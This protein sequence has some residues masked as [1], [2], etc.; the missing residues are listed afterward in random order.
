MDMDKEQDLLKRIQAGMP[1][2][3]KGQKL[4]A[5]FIINHYDKAAYMTAA[6]LGEEVGVSESTV[7]RFANEIGFDGYPKLQ[8]VL[9]EMNKSKLTAVQRI[10]VTSS[11]INEGNILK[12]VLQS[13]MEKIKATLE[14]IDQESFNN[15][16]K[17]IL[18]ARKIYILGVR[19]SAPLASFLGFYFNLIFD[20][21]RLVHTTSVSEMF[22]QIIHASRGDV[23]I[24][25]SFPRYSKRTINAMRFAQ[26]QGAT[27]VAITDSL[28]SPLAKNA[29]HVIT[30]RS[31][32]ASFVDSLVAPLSVI[33]ALI[34]AIGMS[35]KPHVQET[36]E[37]LEKI[38][39]EYKVYEKQD[40]DSNYGEED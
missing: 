37:R 33:N 26:N 12:S 35:R 3:S 25:I 13:D 7:V 17:S 34:V 22:E 15:I 36:F 31:D 8:K 23:V 29:D 2:F 38:W 9:R 11:R 30:A 21:V 18:N 16:V 24:G 40:Y 6:K 1:G 32:M 14:E 4:I 10:E 20:N 39:D 19:S 28:Y 5:N 27:V